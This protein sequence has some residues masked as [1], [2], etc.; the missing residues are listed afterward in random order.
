MGNLNHPCMLGIGSPQKRGENGRMEK[1]DQTT[2]N[3]D[4]NLMKITHL[5]IPRG[6]TNP[7]SKKDIQHLFLKENL[8]KL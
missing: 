8:C 2:G 5:K 7:K 6:S 3:N 1:A 4:P